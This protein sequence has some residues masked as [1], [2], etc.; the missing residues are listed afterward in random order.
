[1]VFLAGYGRRGHQGGCGTAMIAKR[2]DH[3]TCRPEKIRGIEEENDNHSGE[4]EGLN[5]DRIS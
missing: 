4:K 1:M 2:T 5:E 3:T